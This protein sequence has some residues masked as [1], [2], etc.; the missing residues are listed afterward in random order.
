MIDAIVWLGNDQEPGWRVK[1]CSGL[2]A[3][4]VVTNKRKVVRQEVAD[5]LGISIEQVRGQALYSRLTSCGGGM[6][7][8]DN[9]GYLIA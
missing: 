4:S 6:L 7:K 9:G 5:K 8:N 1:D 2:D 3:G